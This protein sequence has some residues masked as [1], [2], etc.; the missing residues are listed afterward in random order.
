MP[1]KAHILVLN[2]DN[3]FL[4]LMKVLLAEEGY[5]A[6]TRKV[7]DNAY[8]VVK[9]SMPDLVILDVLLDVAGRGFQL[10][11]LLTLDPA[12]RSIPLIVASTSTHQLHERTEAFTAMGI[13]VI[14]KPFDLETLLELIRR[15]LKA[16]TREAIREEGFGGPVEEN[17]VVKSGPS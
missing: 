17:G 7:W 11:D 10:I 12:T 14:G 5:S 4:D 13:P 16:G 3:D 15:T 1:K 9:R 8:E 6:E 2:N